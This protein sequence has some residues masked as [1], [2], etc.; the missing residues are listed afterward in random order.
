MM[1]AGNTSETSVIFYQTTGR[2][3]PQDSH[4]HTPSREN[5]KFYTENEININAELIMACA[6]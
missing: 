3:N 4:L 2:Y 1:E 6:T 5:P